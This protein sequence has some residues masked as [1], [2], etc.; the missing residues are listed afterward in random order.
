MPGISSTVELPV[1]R[2][3]QL[4]VE[5]TAPVTNEAYQSGR[6]FLGSHEGKFLLP[7]W[8][9]VIFLFAIH[10][11]RYVFLFDFAGKWL[12]RASRT[13]EMVRTSF[14][15]RIEGRSRDFVWLR[16]LYGPVFKLIVL[17]FVLFCFSISNLHLDNWQFENYPDRNMDFGLMTPLE[18]RIEELRHHLRIESAVVEGAKN[19]IRL[20]QSARST[21]KKALQEVIIVYIL[22]LFFPFCLLPF[23]GGGRSSCWNGYPNPKNRSSFFPKKKQKES[24]QL[25]TG[26]IEK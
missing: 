7:L 11:L 19:V 13:G 1:G 23:Q 26:K 24:I 16:H 14:V 22:F 15:N 5:K 17:N 18:V 9:L 8:F 12:G 3:R 25:K 21:D 10:L 2:R 20:L 6:A 4:F